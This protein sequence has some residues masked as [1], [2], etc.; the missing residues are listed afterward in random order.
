ME[1]SEDFTQKRESTV[2][3]Y[4][5][6]GKVEEGEKLSKDKWGVAEY[7]GEL[8]LC[9]VDPELIRNVFTN[10]IVE[11][12]KARGITPEQAVRI[13][14][15]GGG[16]GVLLDTITKQLVEAGFAKVLGVNIDFTAKHLSTMKNKFMPESSEKND[17][18]I[19]GVQGNLTEM[20]FKEGSFDAG[21]SR[22][23]L[24]YLSKEKQ[25][26]AIGGMLSVLKPGAEL[27]IQ[28]PNAIETEEQASLLDEFDA[29]IDSTI[30]GIPLEDVRGKRHLTS[31]EEIRKIAED[32]GVNCNA[33]F[34][35]EFKMFMSAEIYA[36]RF[37]I[38]DED[39]L[40]KLKD[41]FNNQDFRK[42][43][44]ELGGL[45][46]VDDN[47]KTYIEYKIGLA[48]LKT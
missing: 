1:K 13:V 32:L 25:P 22:F 29:N 30:T 44:Q 40:K 7:K 4:S 12:F 6:L 5:E 17:K 3:P 39:K 20:P 47:G 38:V 34:I 19:Y 43:I 27:I 11:N 16:D 42:K 23:V 46:F 26:E 41:I 48:V 37:N 15:F 35:E 8:V 9:Y 10:R 28:W 2:T 21:Y 31:L 33:D 36:N 24:Q 18:K 45:N 14:D